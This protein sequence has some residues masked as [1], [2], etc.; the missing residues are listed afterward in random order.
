ME[1]EKISVTAYAGYRAD[2]APRDFELHGER[3]SVLATIATWLT[4]DTKTR[5]RRRYFRV[6]GSD[7]RIHDLCYAETTM[8]WF[9]LESVPVPVAGVG[10]T[11]DAPGE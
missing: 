1:E 7:D 4:E 10:D 3:I 8:E 9:H 6:R 5:E 2:E 11:R